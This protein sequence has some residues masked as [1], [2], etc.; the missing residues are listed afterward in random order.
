MIVIAAS[1]PLSIK[2]SRSWVGM[3]T[4]IFTSASW[5]CLKMVLL[6]GSQKMKERIHCRRDE[7]RHGWLDLTT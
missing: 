6:M 5:W 7:R 3:L 1:V 2:R 4:L